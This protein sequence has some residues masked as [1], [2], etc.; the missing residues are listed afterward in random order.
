M[1]K[2]KAIVIGAGP[3]GI[4]CAYELSKKGIDVE[5]F[6]SSGSVGGMSKTID[7]LG[8]RVDLGPHRFFSKDPVVNGFFNKVVK[9]D[10]VVVDRLTR[11][12]Y[13][14]R[15]FLYPLNL[16]NVLK[17]LSFFTIVT[18]LLDFV[19]AQLFPIKD[20]K[21]FEDWVSNRFG[22]KLFNIFFKNYSEK[23]WGISCKELDA[24]WAAQRIKK[25]SLFEAIKGALNV[26]KKGKHATLVDQFKYPTLGTG[27][28]YEKAAE[29]VLENGGK[30]HFNT[31]VNK[32]L[33]EAGTNKA[34]GIEV[35][36]NQVV[37]ADYVV[38]TMP[39]NYL[40]KGLPNVPKTIQK[41]TKELVFRNTILV[42]I[43]VD[44]LDLFDD[45][46]IYVHSPKVKL[47]R[48]TNFRNWSPALYQDKQ[49]TILCLEYWA[50]DDDELWSATEETLS[51]LGIEDL[52]TLQ[53]IS[54]K[55]QAVGAKMIKIPKCYPVYKTGYLKHLKQVEDY[56][57][58]YPN[59]IP[60]GRYG[61][62]KYNN[63][64]HSILMGILAANKITGN[65]KIDLWKINTDTEYQEDGEIKD[66][67]VQ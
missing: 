67:L 16:G 64:D 39:L 7:M 32:V 33:F 12:Y 25:L 3:A 17:N 26:Q 54:S 38:S 37:S 11:I 42:Y 27:D 28:L 40:V 52:L 55:E 6:E 46:W 43:E 2:S 66:V 61:A 45:N 10:F 48:I 9:K 30:I 22:K 34:T 24:Q 63:Q 58:T 51:Q 19:K 65:K 44:G 20:P 41:A 15:F 31:R 62:F 50:Y 59:L 53:L 13:N 35:H 18:V 23:L 5:V 29:Y 56:L 14:E 8:Q 21:S 4:A 1:N 57:D 60:I 49:T 36:D 47:G